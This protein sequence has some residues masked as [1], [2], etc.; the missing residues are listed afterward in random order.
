VR[1]A[2]IAMTGEMGYPSVLSAKTW[3]FQDVSFKGNAVKLARPL[4]SYVMEHVLFK[5]SF[6]AEFHAQTA[7]ECA[8]KLHPLVASSLNE[9]ERVEI[10]THESAIRIIDKSGPLHNPADRDHCL[11]YMTAIGMIFGK[12]TADHYEDQTAAD[13]RIDALRAKMVVTEDKQYSK[14]YLDPKKRSIANAVRVIFKDGTKTSKVAIEY[15][16]GHRRRR[17]EGIP[18]LQQKAL[19]AFAAHYGKAKA[20]KLMALFA[21][22]AKLEAMPVQDFVGAFVK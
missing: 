5:I 4:A 20:T 11:Q 13:P 14:D 2:L 1:L 12:L 7:V 8:I 15:P 18:V 9:I 3:G 17:K 10:A 16:I 19:D 22:R 6:P 21:D